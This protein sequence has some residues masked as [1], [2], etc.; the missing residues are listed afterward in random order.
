MNISLLVGMFHQLHW[1]REPKG[2]GH[3]PSGG[4]RGHSQGE[5]GY[6]QVHLYLQ[7]NFFIV[8]DVAATAPGLGC[9]LCASTGKGK[10]IIGR[11]VL[12][13]CL[14]FLKKHF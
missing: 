9:W 6:Q 14:S 1:H 8:G 11:F 3:V 4:L 12:P 7:M 13:I 5:M 10:K 2:V